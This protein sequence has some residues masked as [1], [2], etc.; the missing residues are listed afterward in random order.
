MARSG[1]RGDHSRPLPFTG[2]IAVAHDEN[3]HRGRRE[4]F[5]ALLLVMF[6]GGGCVLFLT[7]VTGG[8]FLYVLAAVAGMGVFGYVHYL[9]WGHSMTREVAGER[10][11]EEARER[12]EMEEAASEETQP[13]P[14]Q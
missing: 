5:L 12:W 3:P 7:V 13:P 2:E 11:E 14:R 8:F 4:V 10:E 9:L 6:F 1:E